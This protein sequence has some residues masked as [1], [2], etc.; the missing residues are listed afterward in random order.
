M[1]QGVTRGDVTATATGD[2]GILLTIADGES[3]VQIELSIETA[4]KLKSE[5]EAAP[6]T[7]HVRA[8]MLEG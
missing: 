5:V 2:D 4:E 8:R 6:V 3:Q 1:R 7:A